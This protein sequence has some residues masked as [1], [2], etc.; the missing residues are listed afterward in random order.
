MIAPIITTICGALF[1]GTQNFLEHHQDSKKE[2]AIAKINAEKEVAMASQNAVISQ[3]ELQTQESS[4]K[5]EQS[6][7]E[8][9]LRQSEASEY[10]SFSKAVIET[11]K[12][13]QGSSLLANIANFITATLRPFVTY[14]FLITILVL[15]F[16]CIKNEKILNEDILIILE[17]LLTIFDGILSYWFV[18]RSFEKRNAPQFTT[19]KKK[20]I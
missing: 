7:T 14:I 9:S 19:L 8:A 3:N 1:G 13:L 16:Y 11:S 20:M 18:R 5:Q 12:Y 15:V 2:I 10:E 4:T 17:A 6:K